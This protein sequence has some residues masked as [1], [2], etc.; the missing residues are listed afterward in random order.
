MKGGILLYI[1]I[2]GVIWAGWS[3]TGSDHCEIANRF[4]APVRGL[5][6]V[7]RKVANNWVS[8]D[9]KVSMLVYSNSADKT[10]REVI[11]RTF[12]GSDTVCGG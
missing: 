6:W 7:I 2:S 5:A 10:A 1:F 11:A 9:T 12:Y 3:L 4:A 8:D